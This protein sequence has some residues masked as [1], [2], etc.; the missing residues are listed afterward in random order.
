MKI[1][2]L[3]DKRNP[4]DPNAQKI[5]KARELTLTK[6]NNKNIFKVRSIK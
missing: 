4:K 6:K 1:A 5:E 2:S 3:L